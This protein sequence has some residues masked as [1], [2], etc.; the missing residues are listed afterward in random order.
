MR[1]RTASTHIET[2]KAVA[3][4]LG[5]I[6]SAQAYFMAARHPLVPARSSAEEQTVAPVRTR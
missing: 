4:V 6:Y 2:D 1:T 5:D 3:E